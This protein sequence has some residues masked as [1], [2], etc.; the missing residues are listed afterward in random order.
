MFADNAL[1]ELERGPLKEFIE[2]PGK[3]QNFGASHLKFEKWNNH[4]YGRPL[5]SKGYG[6]WITIKS[7]TCYCCKKTFEVIGAHFGGLEKIAA[8]T[9]NFIQ[10]KENICGFIPATIEISD[11]RRGNIFFF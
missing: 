6:G 5:Y 3:W 10:V 8:E 7:T 2:N 9:I 11:E 1:I 4:I